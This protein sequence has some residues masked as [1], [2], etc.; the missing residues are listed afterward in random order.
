MEIGI[1]GRMD[2]AVNVLIWIGTR[3]GGF[4][5]EMEG[6]FGHFVGLFAGILFIV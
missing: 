4:G 6:V 2:E 1:G 5:A 3:R